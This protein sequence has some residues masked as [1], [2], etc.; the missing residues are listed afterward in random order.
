MYICI[1]DIHP[2]CVWCIDHMHIERAMYILKCSAWCIWLHMY[3]YI[4]MYTQLYVYMHRNRLYIFTL[5]WLTFYEYRCL[6]MSVLC[7]YAFISNRHIAWPGYPA[8]K[9]P[10][11]TWA[12]RSLPPSSF[13]HASWKNKMQKQNSTSI[14]KSSRCTKRVLDSNRCTVLHSICHS[15]IIHMSSIYHIIWIICHMSYVIM[16][17]PFSPCRYYRHHC[18]WDSWDAW[19]SWDRT[20]HVAAAPHVRPPE[21]RCGK[22]TLRQWC[23]NGGY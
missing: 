20:A 3:V 2:W 22:I 16:L 23:H 19:D 6:C 4:Y 18:H 21:K 9:S 12:E 8:Q 14:L 11:N 1:S 17:H 7:V 15:Y 5:Q 13:A 10:F